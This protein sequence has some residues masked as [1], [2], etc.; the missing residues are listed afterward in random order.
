MSELGSNSVDKICSIKLLLDAS[1][2]MRLEPRTLPCMGSSWRIR[3]ENGA[4]CG[5]AI[6]I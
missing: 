5:L 3:Y 1:A 2:D 4:A 6:P